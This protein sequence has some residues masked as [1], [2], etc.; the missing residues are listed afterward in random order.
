MRRI[1]DVAKVSCCFLPAGCDVSMNA[2]SVND[3]RRIFCDSISFFLNRAILFS[4]CRV[5]LIYRD[6]H[7][8]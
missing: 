3:G 4:K 2:R 6:D 5:R 7:R 1:N 8:S